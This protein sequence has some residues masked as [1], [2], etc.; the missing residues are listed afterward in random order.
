M[1]WLDLLTLPQARRYPPVPM[2]PP[3]PLKVTK[4]PP[5][6]EPEPELEPKKF[7]S[8]ALLLTS[9]NMPSPLL[10]DVVWSRSPSRCRRIRAIVVLMNSLP[11]TTD[12]LGSYCFF[13]P[14]CL[15]HNECRVSQPTRPIKY[16]F[17]LHVSRG[18]SMS[19]VY[20]SKSQPIYYAD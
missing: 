6:A 5:T 20:S 8:F 9:K 3:S 18:A 7:S 12:P 17:L 19:E 11:E 15:F 13:K 16:I 1:M 4:M 10:V 14:S 2:E